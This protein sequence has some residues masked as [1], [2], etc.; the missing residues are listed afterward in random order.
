[1]SEA[2]LRH[3]A[4]QLVRGSVPGIAI[5]YRQGALQSEDHV[6]GVLLA[7]CICAHGTCPCFSNLRAVRGLK[8][9]SCLRSPE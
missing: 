1:M 8:V 2:A 4:L 3:P 5:Y 7:V 9:P 6:Y